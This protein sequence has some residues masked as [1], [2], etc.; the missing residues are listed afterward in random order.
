[1]TR[2][3]ASF[4]LVRQAFNLKSEING[5]SDQVADLEEAQLVQDNISVARDVLS[6]L[7]LTVT[8]EPIDATDP[9]RSFAI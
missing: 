3:Y 4:D 6:D 1:M 5:L 2:T 9:E 7:R 8:E